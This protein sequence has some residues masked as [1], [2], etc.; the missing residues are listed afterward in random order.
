MVIIYLIVVT[1]ICVI[2]IVVIVLV[3]IVSGAEVG[4][5]GDLRLG[6]QLALPRREAAAG[7][8]SPKSSISII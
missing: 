1:L 5:L 4:V 3:M 8:Q 7:S 6:P 2:V